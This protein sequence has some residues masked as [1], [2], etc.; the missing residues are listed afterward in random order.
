MGIWHC[1]RG[2]VGIWHCNRGTVHGDMALL[3]AIPKKKDIQNAR[4]GSCSRREEVKVKSFTC[5]EQSNPAG[6]PGSYR[7]CALEI[8]PSTC[9]SPI[10]P[11]PYLGG[12][13]GPPEFVV[14]KLNYLI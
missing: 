9:A 10:S 3:H 5:A 7:T 4:Q 6:L 8:N 12:E 2:T 13:T 14:L 11:S 1:N